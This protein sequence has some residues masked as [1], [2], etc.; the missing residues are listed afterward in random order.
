MRPYD[1]VDSASSLTRMIYLS[2]RRRASWVYNTAYPP[3]RVLTSTRILRRMGEGKGEGAISTPDRRLRVFV[4]ATL[5]ELANER[6]AVRKGIEALHLTPVM[7]E[8]GARPHPPRALYRS[9]LEQS[10][11]FVGIYWQ[12]YGWVA[13]GED[14]SGLE[15]EYRLS[16]GMPQLIYIK[17]PAPEREEGLR[18]LLARIRDDDRVSYRR[19]ATPDELAALLADDLAV[20]LSER[21]LPHEAPATASPPLPS[22]T[23]T[24]L[25]TDIEGSTR[26]LQETGS[27]YGALLA[28]HRRLLRD[29]FA[30]HGG[31]EVDTQGDS[32]FVAFAR[33][34]EAVA[35]AAEG[36]RALATHPWP[37]RPVLVRMGVHT[38]EATTVGGAY[39]G[40]D[41]HRAARVAA[42]GHGGQVVV[43]EATAALV[44][45]ALPAG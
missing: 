30:T 20:L 11:V 38:G 17:E 15:D 9:Y 44:G 4:S 40:L 43:S 3:P 27:A 21:F 26:L 23:V 35:A 29:V 33:P 2:T 19:F 7:F 8:V 12:R 28:D 1:A 45:D 14:V 32:F 25:F 5:G 24:F 42:A 36:Q 37:G 34:A 13:P 6:E 39:V 16:S 31:R 41:V 22:G 10:D 18:A